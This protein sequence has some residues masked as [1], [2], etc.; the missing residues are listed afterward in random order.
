M[1]EQNAGKAL[2]IGL[3]GVPHS[4]IEAYV[5][6]GYLPEIKKILASGMELKRI[7]ASIPDVSSTSWA[8]FMTGVNPGEHG[9]YGFMD[10]EPGSY[11]LRFPNYND[12]M[13][14]SIWDITG[15]TAGAR[16]STLYR[17][18]RD[19]FRRPLRS[20][21]LNIPQ[22]YPARTING[23]MTAGFVC[24]DLRKGT[25][26]E[27]AYQFLR[28]IGYLSDVDSDKATGDKD[29]FFEE[30]DRALD[31]RVMAYRHFFVNEPWDTFI[32][33]V[34]ETDRLHHFFYDA[35][36][37]GAHPLHE[38]FVSFYG[39]L[40]HF[41]GEMFHRFMGA[42]RGSGLFMTMSDHGFCGIDSTFNVNAW[43]EKAG[44]LKKRAA[45]YFEMVECGTAA[46]A[47]EPAR[48]YVNAAGRY[49]RGAVGPEKRDSVVEELT[50]ALMS[51]KS[52][53]GRPVIK[54]VYRGSRIYS[55]QCSEEAPDIV[56]VAA[57]GFDLKAGL[58]STD[59]Y[60][61][62]HF[63]GMH[64]QD[65]AHCMASAGFKAPGRGIESLADGILEHL[66][67]ASGLGGA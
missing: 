46:F 59:I 6:L 18:Y 16:T 67:R 50:G 58:R 9:I 66:C 10:L 2:V 12:V 24:P 34:T 60:S 21:V 25:Y 14:P 35:A 61:T 52:P 49:P 5:S 22:T 45:E 11:R 20:I 7:E 30:I 53:G 48:V 38:R 56:A 3:D 32:C 40:D 43:L 63:K 42:T 41:I 62:G 44:Y 47:M 36:L 54:S 33:A 57:E 13:A 8:S 27:S 37:D 39:R 55:G 15:L 4:L 17:K 31:R 29:A 26:P 64:T 19:R 23:V 51:L 65:D 28:S 1:T